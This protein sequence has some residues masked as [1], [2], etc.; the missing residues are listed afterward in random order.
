V[1]GEDAFRQPK[2]WQMSQMLGSYMSHCMTN[3]MTTTPHNYGRSASPGHTCGT[4][5]T[6][7]YLVIRTVEVP[8]GQGVAGSN[9]VSPTGEMQGP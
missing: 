7:L 2:R 9:P 4:S 1:T 6:A 5:K 3:C 8:G